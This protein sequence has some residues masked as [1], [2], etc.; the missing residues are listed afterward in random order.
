MPST[1]T[2]IILHLLAICLFPFFLDVS[3]F[4]W[5]CMARWIKFEG[6]GER[7]YTYLL[8]FLGVPLGLRWGGIVL[9]IYFELPFVVCLL[10]TMVFVIILGFSPYFVTKLVHFLFRDAEETEEIVLKGIE[11]FT[12]SVVWF[13]ILWRSIKIFRKEVK[14][15]FYR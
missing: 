15:F 1:S 3:V 8:L 2:K 5:F 4:I 11:F 14:R 12:L 9:G 7:F 10:L 6:R 13:P